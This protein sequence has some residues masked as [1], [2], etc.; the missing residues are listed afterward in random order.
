VST[1]RQSTK[2]LSEAVQVVCELMR[3]TGLPRHVVESEL[4]RALNKA[5]VADDA[6]APRDLN[7]LSEMASL[8]SRW[9]VEEKYV[10]RLG[11][12][13]PL[14][15]DGR[16][17]T[18]FRLAIDVIG[19]DGAHRVVE[20]VVRRSLVVKTRDGKWRPKSQVVKPRGIDRPQ[21]LRTAVM[22]SRLLRTVAHNSARRYRGE[23]LLFEVMTRVP[24]LPKRFLPT[25]KKFARAQGMTYVRAVD[26]WLESRS[27]PKTRLKARNVREAGVIVFAFEEPAVDL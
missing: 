24:R 3:S 9:H 2:L 26:D 27:L 1:Q 13:R 8:I 11:R 7:P 5:F 16:K 6:T 18:L 12:P 23:D 22:L 17:G 20:N 14:S 10:D 21:I 19:P 4:R 25:F 15:W